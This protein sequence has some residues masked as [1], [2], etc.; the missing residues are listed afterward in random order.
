MLNS[1]ETLAEKFVKKWSWLFF[2]TI[3]WAPLGYIIKIFLT[4]DLTPSEIGI[5]Y[6]II[7][8]V[9]LLSTY[10]DLWL[11][12][13]L[14]YFLP[15]YIIK[16][17]YARCKYLLMLA[18]WMQ[19]LTSVLIGSLLYFGADFLW[20]WHFK[21]EAAI[22]IIEIMS[23]FFVGINLMQVSVILFTASQ[24]TKLQKWVEFF[25]M[26]MTT[27]GVWALFFADIGNLISYAW[28]WIGAIFIT[29]MLASILVYKYYYIWYFEW[30]AMK[31]DMK[32]RRELVRYSIGTFVW[33]NIWSLLHQLDQQIL[34]NMT[35]TTDGWIY[36]IYLSLIG[37]PFIFLSPIIAFLFPVIS[38]IYSRRDTPKI[39]LIHGIFSE[40]MLILVLWMSGIFVM[41]GI[42]I[43]TLLFG[44]SYTESGRAL[45]YIAPFLFLNI[46]I[47]INFQVMAGT[48]MIKKRVVILAKTLIL[49]TTLVIL[50]ISLYK[51]W[52]IP[53]PS[54][55]SATSFA[56]GSSWILMW[57]LSYR[58]IE[59]FRWILSWKW[60]TKN[61][62]FILLW[63]IAYLYYWV[64][65][66]IPQFWFT[67]RLEV[68]PE[69]WFVFWVS[70]IIFLIL[71]IRELRDF[72][73]TV[74]KVRQK[75]L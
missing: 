45:L 60:I 73:Q 22:P 29:V 54:A 72:F 31:R 20:T 11:T 71:N 14:N 28:V 68:V 12:E 4:G 46:L 56:V 24:N 34:Q 43:T 55:A 2:F 62:V 40:T 5:L 48:G 38:E 6:G 39:Q 32:L 66:Y 41:L 64:G 67:G 44:E 53:F 61:L 25:R 27:I 30:V 51:K 75:K 36:A 35:T 49:N 15:R 9:T 50:C 69:I 17:D 70:I 3:I 1:Q 47:Q 21:S 7:S 19:M 58:A 23:L 63:V 59:W 57:I 33:A 8:L 26:S 10:N 65:Q 13:S 37:I 52:I 18:F 16:K 42:P 74:Q